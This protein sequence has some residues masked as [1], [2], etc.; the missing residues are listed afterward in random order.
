MR[1]FMLCGNLGG[2]L[3]D[4][5]GLEMN[6]HAHGH[7]CSYQ[8]ALVLLPVPAHDSPHISQ[9]VSAQT[10]LTAQLWMDVERQLTASRHMAVVTL[11]VLPGKDLPEGSPCGSPSQLSTCPGQRQCVT[12]TA[13][14]HLCCSQPRCQVCLCL[15]GQEDQRHICP[16]PPAYWYLHHDHQLKAFVHGC[17]GL[18]W[19]VQ[20]RSSGFEHL[21]L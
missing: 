13:V 8:W 17:K 14:L 2:V 3:S 21:G 7:W 15:L 18:L 19:H 5:K 9:L 6:V 20:A 11:Q 16:H 1:C 12:V 10:D 4:K